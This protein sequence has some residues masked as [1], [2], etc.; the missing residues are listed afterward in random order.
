MPQTLVVAL[1]LA[2][3]PFEV[4]GG[5]AR[6][7]CFQKWHA[8]QFDRARTVTLASRRPYPR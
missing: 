1:P 8:K 5:E 4:I 6:L 2:P 3:A 7:S